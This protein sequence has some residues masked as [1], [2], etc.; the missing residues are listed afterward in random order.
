MNQT[1]W[2][3]VAVLGTVVLVD[4]IVVP[5]LVRMGWNQFGDRFAP[6]EILPDHIRRNFQ[7]FSFGIFNYG[8]CVHVAADRDHLHLL[9]SKFLR[10][11]R[12]RAMSIP[13]EQIQ[14]VKRR[15]KWIE[16]KVGMI[17]IRGPAWCLELAGEGQGS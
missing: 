1:A 17:T 9:P 5:A 3:V 7:S 10:W 14:V 2:V 15:G 13:W 11:C 12:C 6:A 16:A 4:L 8:M